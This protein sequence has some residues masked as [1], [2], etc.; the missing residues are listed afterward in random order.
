MQ[1]RAH[2]NWPLARSRQTERERERDGLTNGV[3]LEW[4]EIPARYRSG[5]FFDEAAVCLSGPQF[6]SGDNLH[7]CGGGNGGGRLEYLRLLLWQRASRF[8][9]MIWNRRRRRSGKAYRADRDIHSPTRTIR[10]STGGGRTC[11]KEGIGGGEDENRKRHAAG[12]VR[13]FSRN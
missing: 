10:A 5:K 12:R 4:F 6:H 13:V 11:R 3:A 2:G 7:R 8:H 9:S 1:A